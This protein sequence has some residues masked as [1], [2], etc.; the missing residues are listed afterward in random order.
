MLVALMILAATIQP[1][2]RP[3][4]QPAEAAEKKP[5]SRYA[6]ATLAYLENLRDRET[7]TLQAMQRG[8]VG[9]PLR[10]RKAPPEYVKVGHPFRDL[11]AGATKYDDGSYS[12]QTYAHK[13]NAIRE[14]MDRVK[15]LEDRIDATKRGEWIEGPPL[16]PP[17]TKGQFGRL[18][19]D[20]RVQQVVDDRNALVIYFHETAPAGGRN[21]VWRAPDDEWIW[22][23]VEVD[24]A[25]W[26]DETARRLP[27][28][29]EVVGTRRYVT[30]TGATKTVPVLKE[31]KLE[32][33]MTTRP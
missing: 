5:L 17:F 4:T 30:V 8:T 20:L 1:S 22:L 13:R 31:I 27:G 12:F 3:A 14:Q 21:G 19:T 10:K 15:S 29:W 24:T 2:T 23:W 9:R 32:N 26:T 18:T 16:E 25:G 7:Q 33:K 28:N 11:P 6:R